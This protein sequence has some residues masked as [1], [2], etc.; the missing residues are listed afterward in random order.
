MNFYKVK[1]S[2]NLKSVGTFPQVETGIY[3]I[4]DNNP[5]FIGNNFLKKIDFQA[6]LSIPILSKKAK[7]TDLISCSIMGFSNSLLIS[8]KLKFILEKYVTNSVQFFEAPIMYKESKVSGYWI[9]HPYKYNYEAINYTKCIIR[10]QNLF[11]YTQKEAIQINSAEEFEC[12]ISER[13]KE[14]FWSYSFEKLVLQSNIPELI[15]LIG[16]QGLGYCV[17]EKV[18][19]EI[20]SAGCTGIEFEPVEQG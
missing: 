8:T 14:I 1:D 13:N 12:L 2:T 18:K 6:E 4:M 15:F 3:P 10:R 5:N 9:T 16:I 17:S 11:D 7:L 19:Q 20:E